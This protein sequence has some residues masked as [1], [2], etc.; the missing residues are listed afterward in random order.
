MK[1]ILT[2]A[3]MFAAAILC[4]GGCSMAWDAVKGSGKAKTETRPITKFSKIEV[5]GT[6][7]LQVMIGDTPSLEITTDDN[8]LPLVET[9]VEGDTLKI[10][11]TK[12]VDPKTGIHI[13]VVAPSLSEVTAA[14][15]NDRRFGRDDD[16]WFG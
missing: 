16:L 6:G 7:D 5:A 11:P 9:K 2:L 3:P 14:G 8:I 13:K 1:P 12:N 10:N 15:S 4:A